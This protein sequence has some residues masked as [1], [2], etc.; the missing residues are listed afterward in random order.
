MAT[1]TF[2]LIEKN[3]EEIR[4]QLIRRIRNRLKGSLDVI[5]Q[6]S[7]GGNAS[8]S[9]RGRLQ[10]GLNAWVSKDTGNIASVGNEFIDDGNLSSVIFIY[11][12]GEKNFESGDFVDVRETH[13]GSPL[14]EEAKKL[15]E[16]VV[17][18]K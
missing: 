11:E 4:N 7:L 2:N 13:L 8:R 18:K 17:G 15:L 14:S 16:E 1:E 10:A 9:P 12:V 6:E 5:A 3:K